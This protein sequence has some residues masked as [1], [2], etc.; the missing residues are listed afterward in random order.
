MFPQ[1]AKS[2]AEIDSKTYPLVEKIEHPPAEATLALVA[3][4]HTPV[5]RRLYAAMLAAINGSNG[6]PESQIARAHV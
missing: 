6:R 2:L 1:K 5:E 4:S 3:L